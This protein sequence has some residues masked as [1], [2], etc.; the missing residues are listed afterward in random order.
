R[1]G[2][3]EPL[4]A[5]SARRGKGR[6]G[7][8]APGDAN[9]ALWQKG[10]ESFGIQIALYRKRCFWSR[11][12]Y[13]FSG[14]CMGKQG[15]ERRYNRCLGRCRKSPHWSTIGSDEW[16]LKSIVLQSWFLAGPFTDRAPAG[17]LR[18]QTNSWTLPSLGLAIQ[19]HGSERHGRKAKD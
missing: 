6:V 10:G 17:T 19:I 8:K 3:T 16:L 12:G 2:S 15:G 14:S 11:G 18:P 9:R 7:S 5:H 4:R 1:W 13:R